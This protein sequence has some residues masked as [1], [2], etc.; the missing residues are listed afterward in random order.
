MPLNSLVNC[1]L[2]EDTVIRPSFSRQGEIKC[3]VRYAEPGGLS[4]QLAAGFRP[5]QPGKGMENRREVGLGQGRAAPVGGIPKA[6]GRLACRNQ[7][8]WRRIAAGPAVLGIKDRRSRRM[9]QNDNGRAAS[10]ETS[11]PVVKARRL[12]AQ[13][14]SSIQTCSS[15]PPTSTAIF[16]CYCVAPMKALDFVQLVATVPNLTLVAG[17]AGIAGETGAAPSVDSDLVAGIAIQPP[18]P[19][20]NGSG[21]SRFSSCS[22]RPHC[23]NPS[24]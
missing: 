21:N 13:A 19:A 17:K 18:L 12:E 16:R 22:H 8:S 4:T 15:P 24:A 6:R 10:V 7:C 3:G 5:H 11:P 2:T 1:G 20:P 14:L 9:G 23:P